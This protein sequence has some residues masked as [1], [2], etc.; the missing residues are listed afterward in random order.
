M[1]PTLA[2]MHE[3]VGRAALSAQ[4]F[5][6]V[7]AVCFQLLGILVTGVSSLIDE[8]RFKTPTRNLIKELSAANNIAPEF[9][10]Q[11]DALIDKRHLLIHRWYQEC[12]LPGEED[13]DDISKLTL[14]AHDV[15]QES[16]RISGLL[17]GYIV[18]WGRF[19]LKQ[20]L[21]ADPERTRML[22]LFQRAHLGDT[23]E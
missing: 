17:A 3:A 5:E 2:Q 15:E 19:N 8:K 6:T 9:E 1:T 10:E 23:G 14:L 20:N 12:G 22:A 11:L 7:F 13:T 16:K 21:L 18:C 4:V